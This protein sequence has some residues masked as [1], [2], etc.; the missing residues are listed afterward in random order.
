MAVGC[1]EF[2]QV[3][4][5]HAHGE[6]D[7]SL[8]GD[9]REVE[10]VAFDLDGTLLPSDKCITERTVRAIRQASAA[11]ITLVP[12]TGRVASVVPHE[13]LE[14]PE[15][16]F[17]ICSAGASVEAITR[18][19]LGIHVHALHEVGFTPKQAAEL[20]AHVES[21]CRDS[22]AVD[23]GY[24][25]KLYMSRA[26]LDRVC[27]FELPAERIEFIGRSR[28]PV[29]DLPAALREFTG[30]VGRVN[31]FA[32]SE[33]VRCATKAWLAKTLDVELA[34]SLSD[35]IE[36]N[37]PGTSKWNGLCWLA[38]HMGIDPSHMLVLGDGENDIDMLRRAT[39]GVAMA[40]AAESIRGKARAVTT[41]TNDQDGVAAVLEE[42][43]SLKSRAGRCPAMSS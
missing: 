40:N 19:A 8:V 25:G 39:V 3:R 37:A 32:Q 10:L 13:L 14:L 34:N 2:D 1:S 4:S 41:G 21:I 24:G 23:A 30:L 43:V 27:A 16:H 42:I 17:A 35:N 11:G 9:L 18:G 29:D 28:I 12:A 5:M 15:I 33:R 22:L 38:D 26:A 7:A 6:R 31:L 20:V 36:L